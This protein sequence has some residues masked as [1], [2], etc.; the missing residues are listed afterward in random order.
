VAELFLALILELQNQTDGILRARL[1]LVLLLV[2]ENLVAALVQGFAEYLLDESERLVLSEE[3][4]PLHEERVAK[5]DV[6]RC[7]RVLLRHLSFVKSAWLCL[8]DFAELLDRLAGIFVDEDVRS[9]KAD[10]TLGADKLRIFLVLTVCRT[11]RHTAEV[12]LA[13]EACGRVIARLTLI[14]LPVRAHLEALGDKG[15]QAHIVHVRLAGSDLAQFLVGDKA[16]VFWSTRPGLYILFLHAL[17][18]SELLRLV[19]RV[20]RKND[21]AIFVDALQN[22]LKLVRKD[23]RTERVSPTRLVVIDFCTI[24][25]GNLDPASRQ[26]EFSLLFRRGLLRGLLLDLICWLHFFG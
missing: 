4:L 6:L 16:R 19:I 13:E 23:D 15:Q 14:I 3:F 8:D 9:D 24:R 18:L 1:R 21:L 20:L 7:D 26:L 17:Q 2:Q 22:D 10:G 25:G 5:R 12:E 11:N